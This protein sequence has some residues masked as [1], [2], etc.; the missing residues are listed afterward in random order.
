MA[1]HR[2]IG[3]ILF[4]TFAAMLAACAGAAPAGS[5]T[6]RASMASTETTYAQFPARLCLDADTATWQ[7]L[8]SGATRLALHLQHGTPSG[9]NSPTLNVR[10]AGDAK[11]RRD[12]ETLTPG[13]DNRGEAGPVPQH[14]LIN[15]AQ[16]LAGVAETR[17][18]C[19]EV[20]VAQGELDTETAARG[21]KISADWQAIRK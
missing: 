11:T 21:V 19:I 3:G 2:A 8:R 17:Q 14:F 13:I 20:D 16:A 5:S 9:R 18:V 4:G 15:L 6:V 12:V 10:L 7:A 1:Y